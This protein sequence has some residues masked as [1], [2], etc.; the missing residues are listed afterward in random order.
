MHKNGVIKKW[1]AARGFGFIRTNDSPSDVFFHHRAFRA[2]SGISPAEGLPVVFED[3]HVG[4][5]GPRATS[6]SPKSF[7]SPQSLQHKNPLSAR[8]DTAS[9]HR[10]ANRPVHSPSRDARQKAYQAPTRAGFARQVFMT[11]IFSVWLGLAFYSIATG[12]VSFW[13]L[14]WLV[15]INVATVFAYAFDKNAAEQ[16][17]WRTSEQTLHA[18]SLAGGWPAAWAAQQVMRHKCSKA[19]FQAMYNATIFFDIAALVLWTFW[20]QIHRI[21][22]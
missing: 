20:L 22:L 19:S 5:K 12:R 4:G 14:P 11:T 18:F 2:P 9:L 21:A 6:V 13:L 16:G 10:R 1:D 15:L 17:Q 3:M 8:H 7:D